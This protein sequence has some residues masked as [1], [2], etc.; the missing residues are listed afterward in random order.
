MT[1]IVKLHVNGVDYELALDTRT[2]L[3]DALRDHLGLKGVKKS[4]DEDGRTDCFQRAG[5]WCKP[6]AG[7]P[8]AHPF[9]VEDPN[10]LQFASR[11]LPF[12]RVKG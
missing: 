6:A 4:C 7:P 2:T 9:R 10:T 8:Q 12:A 11:R 3:V 1:Q 5:G